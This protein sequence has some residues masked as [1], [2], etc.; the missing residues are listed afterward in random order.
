MDWTS[1]NIFLSSPK[2]RQEY[3]GVLLRHQLTIMKSHRNGSRKF[4]DGKIHSNELGPK[5]SGYIICFLVLSVLIV[6]FEMW[7]SF[8]YEY[9]QVEFYEFSWYRSQ[10]L[11]NAYKHRLDRNMSGYY[12]TIKHIFLRCNFVFYTSYQ[13]YSK[14]SVICCLFLELQG[15]SYFTLPNRSTYENY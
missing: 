7:E 11:K 6:W 3:K 15:G 9:F 8:F 10:S 2:S 14:K 13:C 12:C 1:V 4:G 5:H